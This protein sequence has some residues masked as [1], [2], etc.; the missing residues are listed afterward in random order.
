LPAEVSK[1]G[2]A[3]PRLHV[4]LAE[5]NAVNQKVA[6]ALLTRRG[7]SFVVVGNGRLAVE[8]HAVEDFDLILMD[9]QMPEMDGWD[10]T[11]KIREQDRARGR[12]IPI[13][14]L[15]AHAMSHIREQCLDAGMDA[16]IVKPFDPDVFYESIEGIALA[17]TRA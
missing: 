2:T 14:A 12:R 9:L 10:A 11:R 13:I 5:D 17:V 16:V 6:S 1:Q 7:H 8:R 4:L 3:S 15:T